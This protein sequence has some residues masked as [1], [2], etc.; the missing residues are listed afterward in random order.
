MAGNGASAGSESHH[1]LAAS[2]H[3]PSRPTSPTSRQA[4]MTLQY[5][6][7]VKKV[8]SSPATTEVIASSSSA[9][10]S[11]TRPASISASPWAWMPMAARS[12]SP[13]RRPTSVAR[14]A[15]AT[16]SSLS[17]RARDTVDSTPAR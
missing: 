2:F 6:T 10:P 17:P 1:C 14:S 12:G 9:I 16:A 5:T 3:S 13:K 11:A 8:P 15:R 7:P 4:A